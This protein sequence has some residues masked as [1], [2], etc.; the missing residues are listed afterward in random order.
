MLPTAVSASNVVNTVVVAAGDYIE[1]RVTKAAI[2][3]SPTDIEV[4][5]EEA[6]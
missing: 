5:I 3:S 1:I 6:A 4:C 2:G